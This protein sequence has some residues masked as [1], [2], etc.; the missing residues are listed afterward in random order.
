MVSNDPTPKASRTEDL[1]DPNFGRISADLLDANKSY[2][3]HVYRMSDEMLQAIAEHTSFTANFDAPTMRTALMD[4]WKNQGTVIIEIER[5][6][7]PKE[8]SVRYPKDRWTVLEA[9]TVEAE[10]MK[11]SVKTEYGAVKLAGKVFTTVAK[12]LNIPPDMMPEILL[13]INLK[14]KTFAV[15]AEEW[16]AEKLPPDAT[17]A[18]AVA[19]ESATAAPTKIVSA[20]NTTEDPAQAESSAVAA[21]DETADK[22]KT[23]S[24]SKAP[25]S[26]SPQSNDMDQQQ[27]YSTYSRSEVDQLLK[28]Q[29]EQL[30]ATLGAKIS[31]QQRALQ[32]AMEKQEKSFGR[33]TESMS[34]TM[35]TARTKLETASKAAS[36]QTTKDLEE[37]KK[38]LGKELESYRASINKAS[39][40]EVGK[41]AAG[42]SPAKAE[43]AP[44]TMPSPS[45]PVAVGGPPARDQVVMALL[46]AAIVAAMVNMITIMLSVSDV[47]EHLVGIE[48]KLNQ[49]SP[50]TAPGAAP[51][52]PK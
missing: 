29:A 49:M 33:M 30:A 6:A 15:I 44:T 21:V 34:S 19:G 26:V 14:D 37:F 32:E 5:N 20:V 52:A 28:Q 4:L 47:K 16:L 41:P 48:S 39:T 43:R 45:G 40:R 27:K 50:T 12:T 18:A 3:C 42:E 8:I 46:V 7:K 36:D 13:R 2:R 38:T 22:V 10:G 17:T 9:L 25:K 51:A 31:Q 11:P 1:Q 24:K 23:A 35:D